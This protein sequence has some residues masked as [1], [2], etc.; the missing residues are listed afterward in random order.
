MCWG[1]EASLGM[2][3]AGTAATALA[4]ARRESP[5]IWITLGWFTLMEGLQAAGYAVIDD[6]ADPANRAITLASALHIALQPFFINAFALALLPQRAS[7]R[8]SRR[9]W[10]ACALCT[11]VMLLQLAPMPAFGD[12]RPGDP[13]CGATMCTVSGDWHLA[14]NV[15]YNGLAVPVDDVLDDVVGRRTGFPTYVIAAFV[16]P[17]LYGAWR[18]ALLNFAAGPVI[19][20]AL[21]SNPN[22]MPAIWCLFS[23][24]IVLLA[25]S[26]GLRRRFEV[27]DWPLWPS[28]ARV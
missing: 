11:A 21:T 26:A 2:V 17:A 14:W 28:G 25:S 27:Q 18:F 7:A 4:A 3:V 5:A 24:V 19:S 15:P 20:A 6:C 13:M 12:C 22:E 16:L 1:A 10:I 8:I 9:V 23:V